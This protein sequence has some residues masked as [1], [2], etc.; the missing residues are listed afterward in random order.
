VRRVLEPLNPWR[1]D[2]VWSCLHTCLATVL[3]YHGWNPVLTLGASWRFLHIPGDVRG[4][5][6][7]YPCDERGLA[8]ALAPHHPLACRWHSPPDGPAGREQVREA[9]VRGVPAIVAVDNFHLPFRPAWND[10]HAAHLVLVYGFDDAED[11]VYVLDATPPGCHGPIRRE[12]LSA[13]RDSSNPPRAGEDFFASTPIANRW[14]EAVPAGE[15]PRLSRGWVAGVVADNLRHFDEASQGPGLCGTAGLRQYLA[16]VVERCAGPE[17][18][19]ALEE[20]YIFGWPVQADAA[21]HA[22]FLAEAG[23]LL[24]WPALSEAGRR[25]DRLT[26][27]WT[28]LRVTGG[29]GRRG[30][31]RA[32]PR[33]ARRARS[34]LRDHE[35]A[36]EELAW[37]MQQA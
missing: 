27:H 1:H 2:D 22:A 3:A 11:T 26:H 9:I 31:A 32:A 37:V 30:P 36:L 33:L 16:G 21:W 24:D 35:E 20:L 19:A 7:Y 8:D 13:A 12:D 23:R 15:P 28:A 25:I 29:H 10:V 34:L 5:E 18:A 14:L 17:G 6:Y 4:E